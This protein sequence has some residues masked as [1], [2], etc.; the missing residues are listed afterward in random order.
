MTPEN[1]SEEARPEEYARALL[2]LA[3]VADSRPDPR[4]LPSWYVCRDGRDV[5]SLLFDA[6]GEDD[7]YALKVT[8][9]HGGDIHHA[10]RPED[11]KRPLEYALFKRSKKVSAALS[12]VVYPLAETLCREPYFVIAACMDMLD[13]WAILRERTRPLIEPLLL[14]RETIRNFE[15]VRPDRG[16]D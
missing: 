12:K 11:G 3:E 7:L 4:L 6:C 1:A 5:V 10:V 15:A 13:E 16:D 14:A 8:V 2:T 9:E